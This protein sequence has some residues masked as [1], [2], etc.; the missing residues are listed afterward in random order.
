MLLKSKFISPSC[1]GVVIVCFLLPFLNVKCNDV[2]LATVKGMDLVTGS[3]LEVNNLDL[4]SATKDESKQVDL[5]V[6]AEKI[7]RN[8]FAVAALAL[9]I[10]GIVLSFLL[11]MQREMLLGLTGIG[12]ALSLMLMRI[13]IDNSIQ[14]Q[15]NGISKYV[16]HIDYVIGYWLA[17][18]FFLAAGLFNIFQY[19]ERMK[20]ADKKTPGESHPWENRDS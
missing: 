9:A 20:I 4:P 8:Y 17:I 15:T 16:I 18:V 7:E 2:N 6:N 10:C 3:H 11:V 14:K 5:D 1:F 19:M 13:Q 12:G